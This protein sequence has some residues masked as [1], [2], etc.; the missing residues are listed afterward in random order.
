[1]DKEYL[2]ARI[3]SIQT[4]LERET[5]N[6]ESLARSGPFEELKIEELEQ[7]YAKLEDRVKGFDC[8]ISHLQTTQEWLK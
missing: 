5:N 8:L 1:M 3:A 7:I 2:R 4:D 6:L